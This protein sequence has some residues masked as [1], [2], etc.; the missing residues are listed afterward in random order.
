[1]VRPTLEA[2]ST[3]TCC[4]SWI[5]TSNCSPAMVRCSTLTPKD[6]SQQRRHGAA[7]HA[8]VADS[9]ARPEPVDRPTPGD[10]STYHHGEYIGI[11]LSFNTAVYV[12]PGG[13]V[14]GRRAGQ[15][16]INRIAARLCG[17]DR[18]S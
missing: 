15:E 14:G 1:M 3:R 2:I 17:A 18:R 16:R 7:E 8:F 10:G 9:P 4:W 13:S 5:T 11:A 6:C 12:P